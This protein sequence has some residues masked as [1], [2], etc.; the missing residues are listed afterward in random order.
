[1]DEEYKNLSSDEETRKEKR[2][3]K[4]KKKIKRFET[5]MMRKNILSLKKK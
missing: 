2:K 5:K 4:T 1:V 3:K